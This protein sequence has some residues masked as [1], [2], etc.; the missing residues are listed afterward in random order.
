MPCQSMQIFSE[1][2][3]VQNRED[4][5][6][7]SLKEL[8]IQIKTWRAFIRCKFIPFPTISASL[9]RLSVFAEVKQT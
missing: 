9:E 3:E 7:W 6:F 5:H 1:N 2:Q 4:L 8:T